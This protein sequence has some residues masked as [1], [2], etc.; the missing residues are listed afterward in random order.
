[1]DPYEYA[2]YDCV[3]I[4]FAGEPYS[5]DY[6]A[7]D[8]AIDFDEYTFGDRHMRYPLYLY[9]K[10]GPGKTRKLL[11]EAE[12]DQIMADKK[13]FCNFIFG[14]QTIDGNR[15]KILQAVSEYKRVDSI[16]SFLNNME[17]G[18]IATFG[19]NGS[20]Y[21][22]VAKSKF[23]IS[24]ESMTQDGFTTEKIKDA[25]NCYSIPIYF[26]NKLIDKEF[27]EK[28]FINLNKFDTLSD[29]VKYISEIDSNDTIYKSMLMQ[30]EYA[31][32]NYPNLK[33]DELKQVLYHIFDQEQEKAFRRNRYYI[34]QNY[35]NMQ[36]YTS[37]QVNNRIFSK[38]Y[39]L[40]LRLMKK[41]KQ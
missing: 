1:M 20:K 23:T 15:E 8:Y 14:H 22:Y 38:F 13:Y 31:D 32:P 10:N 40:Y 30:C 18:E 12:A 35:N 33:Y 34:C 24:A 37:L 27:N 41:K 9:E 6:N 29:G 16:G 3:R 5:A 7:C 21:D 28:A 39:R 25:F 2:N 11:S 26:G 19:P 36:R 17:N 4:M